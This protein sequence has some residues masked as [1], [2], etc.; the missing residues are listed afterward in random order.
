MKLYG[1][2]LLFIFV[3]NLFSWG[4]N[5]L[6]SAITN[7]TTKFADS[8][9]NVLFGCHGNNERG[10]LLGFIWVL[11]IG[12]EETLTRRGWGG[13][14]ERDDKN[15]KG[16]TAE[17]PELGNCMSRI[18][19]WWSRIFQVEDE[20]RKRSW[21]EKGEEERILEEQDDRTGT[22][23]WC[24]I[25]RSSGPKSNG[26]LITTKWDIWSPLPIQFLLNSIFWQILAIADNSYWSL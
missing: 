26:N 16:L 4:I 20:G 25:V 13:A 17:I 5:Y 10:K 7:C 1:K 9:G 6:T 15:K 12:S 8:T 11:H 14:G 21:K 3:L 24:L 18:R 19:S 23:F 2:K 22:L